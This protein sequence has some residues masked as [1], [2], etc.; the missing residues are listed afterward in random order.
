M[1]RVKTLKE[2]LKSKKLD[3]LV[4]FHPEN[5]LLSSGM[6]PGAAFTICMFTRSGAIT[7]ISPWWREKEVSEQS[8]ADKVISFN[9][10]KNLRGVDPSKE[11]I[12]EL[13]R[14][15]NK[16]KIRKIGFDGDM[17]CLMPSYTPSSCFTYNLLKSS[18]KEIFKKTVDVSADIHRLRS[19]KTD[20][21]IGKIKKANMVSQKAAWAFYK[22]A[23]EGAREIDV[24]ADILKAVQL[25]AGKNGIKYTY[26]DPPQITSG[27]KR[28]YSANA[29]SCP[30]TKR[31][32]KKN[33]LV[34]LELGGCVDGYWFDLTRTLVVGGKAKNIHKDMVAA[35][36]IAV[37][38]TYQAYENGTKECHKLTETAFEVLKTCG[39]KKAILHGL[40]HGVGYSY[41]EITPGIG[42]GSNDKIENGMVTSMEPGLYLPTV[43]G[44]RIE[45]NVLWKEGSLT[46][47]SNFHNALG[48]WCE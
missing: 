42:P 18:L 44:I 19:I 22:K 10:L 45:E 28:T 9:W 36:S 33:D 21:E 46:V 4:F 48:N 35:L 11:I 8:W 43:G 23:K 34:M 37:K 26:C 27:V 40:G 6:L 31:K 5:I 2:L 15:C 7:V 14:I 41:H 16:S 12:N 3:G 20:H 47:L 29:L 39:F 25:Q 1:D 32:F 24:A 38:K 30:A 17:G 13:E